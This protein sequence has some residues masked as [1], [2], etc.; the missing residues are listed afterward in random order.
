MKIQFISP[1]K[2]TA[3]FLLLTLAACGG[4]SGDSRPLDDSS[5]TPPI[6]RIIAE[7]MA[8]AGELITFSGSTSSNNSG[9]PLS[10]SWTVLD[11]PADSAYLFGDAESVTSALA[12][13]RAGDYV[14]Q[15]I[16]SD[17]N[18]FSEPATATVTVID[19][20]AAPARAPIQV[21]ID[22]LIDLALIYIDTRLRAP[23]TRQIVSGP[24]WSHFDSIGEP[25]KGSIAITIDSE[26]GFGVPI[27]TSVICPCNWDE[28]GFWENTLS[29]DLELC[30][31]F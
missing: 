15:L 2:L 8:N 17:G 27:R 5:N 20:G 7:S 23:A 19:A 12:R 29:P 25:E 24:A 31:F 3:A 9:K 14:V 18:I 1:N 6:A 26:N 28:R 4:G 22:N 16:V 10:Y 30:F 11:S 13:T 21:E